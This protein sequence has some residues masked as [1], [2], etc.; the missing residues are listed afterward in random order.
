MRKRL[1]GCTAAASSR[2]HA[3]P[4]PT[5]AG[6]RWGRVALSD[7]LRLR[8]VG[9]TAVLRHELVEF[10]LVFGVTQAVEEC[11]EFVLLFFETAQGFGAVLVKRIVAARAAIVGAA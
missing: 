11:D 8:A 4:S 2:N 10:R 7:G 6:A 3:S 1:P 5:I 9:G